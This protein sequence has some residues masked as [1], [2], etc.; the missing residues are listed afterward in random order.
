[1][2]QPILKQNNNN[3]I[4]KSLEEKM[5]EYYLQ[6]ETLKGTLKEKFIN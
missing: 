1:M 3:I 5:N 4:N 6:S 2:L